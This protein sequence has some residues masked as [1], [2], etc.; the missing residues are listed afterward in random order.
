MTLRANQRA[1]SDVK[2]PSK[3]PMLQRA[4]GFHDTRHRHARVARLTPSYER[5]HPPVCLTSRSSATVHSASR[6][7]LWR[8]ED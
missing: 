7:M 8:L 5:A 1:R 4:I 6:P 2:A 3:M